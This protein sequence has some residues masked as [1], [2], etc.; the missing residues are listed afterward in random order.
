MH[1]GGGVMINNKLNKYLLYFPAA[2]L[3][4]NKLRTILDRFGHSQWEPQTLD[5]TDFKRLLRY[6]KN[7]VP[8]YAAKFADVDIDAMDSP[9]DIALLPFTTKAEIKQN[10]AQFVSKERFNFLTVKTTGG[11]TGQPVTILKTREAMSYELAATWRGYSWAGIGIGD[12][13]A[14]LWGV[15]FDA[16]DRFKARL[17][18]IVCNR[19]RLSAFSFNER[20]LRDYYELICRSEPAYFYGYV[21]MLYEFARFMRSNSLALSYR[22]KAVIVT[23]EVLYRQQR[24]LIADAF[25]AGVFNEYGCGEV[26][27]IA[28]ECENG[29]LHYSPENIYLEI[30][31]G[32]TPCRPGQIGELCVTELH[33]K[34]FPLIRYR[35]GDFAAFKAGACGCGRA[36]PMISD[37]YGRQ[38][39]IVKTRDGRTFHGEFFM[40]IFEEI[41]RANLGVGRFQ[42][43]QSAIDTFEI[44]IV[45]EE[46]Y[47][48]V[49]TKLISDRVRQHLGADCTVKIAFVDDIQRERSG[50]MRLIIG[51]EG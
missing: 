37:V 6:C 35:L 33:N 21:S 45:P 11:S 48:E 2:F 47:S 16:S 43:R 26:G 8:A 4:A 39:D 27:S 41:K 22:P 12:K 17:K 5:L 36:L 40:Y 30:L 44:K 28:H 25:G 42:V 7:N 29:N 34:A 9:D 3:Y 50:K 23:S 32:E 18:D 20:S 15:P 51:L 38:Y 31:D 10:W 24:D 14:R 46:N 1:R 19:M 13:Q 49:T